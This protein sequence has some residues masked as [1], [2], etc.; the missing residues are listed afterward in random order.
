[1]DNLLFGRRTVPSAIDELAQSFPAK[2]WASFPSSHDEI[3]H[4]SF[5]SCATA[6]NTAAWW[7]KKNLGTSDTFQTVAYLGPNDIRYLILFC[8]AVKCGY[9]ILFTSPRNSREGHAQLFQTTSCTVLLYDSMSSHRSL[10]QTPCLKVIPV[11]SL[12]DLLNSK[13]IPHFP[14]Q[15]TFDE[16]RDDP[17]VVL[18]TSGTTS[19]PKAIT[20]SHGQLA[21]FDAQWKISPLDGR[22]VFLQGM[23]TCSS[24]LVALPFFHMAGFSMGIWLPLNPNMSVVF[25]SPLKPLSLFS[26]EQTLDSIK[27]GG[28]IIPPSLLQEAVDSRP[29]LDKIAR[30]KHVFYGGA[31]LSYEAG[32]ALSSRTHLCNQI[33]STESVVLTTHLTDR[34]DWDYICFGS[35]CSGYDFRQTSL[36]DMFELVIM[37]KHDKQDLQAVFQGNDMSEFSTKDLYSKHPRKPHHW[38]YQGRLDDIIVLSHGEKLNPISNESL[39]GSHPLLRSAMYIGTGK[40]HPAVILELAEGKISR[41]DAKKILEAVWPLI[42]QANALS[43]SYSQLCKSHLIIADPSKKFLRTTKGT[44]KRLRT[45]QL[46]KSEIRAIY[47]APVKLPD[48]AKR[49]DISRHDEL[50]EFVHTVYQ[51]ASKLE[52]LQLDED[53]FLAGADSLSIQST[54]EALKASVFLPDLRVDTSWISQKAV[55]ANPTT[56][57]MTKFLESLGRPQVPPTEPLLEQMRFLQE[58]YERYRRQLPGGGTMVSKEAPATATVLLT[59][60]TGNLGSYVLGSLL[61]RDDVDQVICLNRSEDAAER[62]L[63]RNAEKGLCTELGGPRVKFLHADLSQPQFGLN[64]LDYGY[65]Q[66]NVTTILHIQWPVNFNLPLSSFEPQL[67]GVVNLV[68]LA[69]GAAYNPKFFFVSSISAVNNWRR[70]IHLQHPFYNVPERH[71]TDLSLASSGYGQSKAITSDLLYYASSQCGLRGTTL[72]LGQVAGPPSENIARVGSTSGNHTATQRGRLDTC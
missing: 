2:S 60:S 25:T 13:N 61:K 71:F 16:A 67:Q 4:V 23:G 5:S 38:K 48:P 69:V 40:P 21:V 34:T 14:F 49:I 30:L 39:I 3:Q 24:F 52:H 59:G 6:V 51:K 41:L 35:E 26:I 15:K 37:R 45:V 56:R 57:S 11:P 62:Q 27:V 32:F 20:L 28:A 68:N 50:Q 63:R 7:L 58:V 19:I 1:M 54:V 55:Y 65:I 43:P 9:K 10:P 29:M 12:D 17:C 36:P 47:D 46:F 42:E 18:H 66:S 31:P 22:Q 44:L 53:I 8:A 64:K 33:G 70:Q 72:R